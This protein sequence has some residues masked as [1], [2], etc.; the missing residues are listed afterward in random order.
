[1]TGVLVILGCVALFAPVLA[2]YNPIA[3]PDIVSLKNLPPSLAHPFGTDPYSRDV[4][5]RVMYGAR[6]S[7]SVALLATTVTVLLGT[8]YGAIAGYAGGFVETCMMRLVDALMSVPRVLLVIVVVALW[9]T[10][11]LWLL[12]TV[13]GVTGWFSL[14]RLVRGQ[15][16]AFR[17]R[18]FVAAADALGASRTRILFR[19]ILPNVV[20]VIIVDATLGI[21]QVIVLEAGL[22][23]LGLGVQPPAASWG[24]IIQD[25]ADQIS[26]LWWVSLFPGLL[27]AMTA[28]ACN[29]LG[30]SLRDFFDPRE[31][32]S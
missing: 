31:I 6:V 8:I 11:P 15:V 17:Q 2:P 28:V 14:S 12:I 13:I 24:N 19:H 27:I 22:S 20:P 25:G 18:D 29:A 16:L 23:Y 1:M 9:H 32:A 21:G 7:L 10:L 30:D 26:T 4:L 3:Q 5:S